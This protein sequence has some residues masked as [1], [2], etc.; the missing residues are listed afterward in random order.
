MR[1][2]RRLASRLGGGILGLA[3]LAALPYLGAAATSTEHSESSARIGSRCMPATFSSR[4][5][6][7]GSGI[8]NGPDLV[9]VDTVSRKLSPF[10]ISGRAR[11]APPGPLAKSWSD[12]YPSRIAVRDDGRL[13]VQ[14]EANGFV[15]LD[16]T[17]AY[18]RT[19]DASHLRDG[20][21][22]DKIYTWAPAG[23]DVVAFADIKTSSR[24]GQGEQWSSGVVRFSL[25]RDQ[26]GAGDRLLP[27]LSVHDAS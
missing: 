23:T 22:V 12:L 14:A 3:L 17:Y 15:L 7:T 16:R 1:F 13:V 5:L 27:D 18:Q 10:S 24:N 25:E 4:P 26:E 20:S 8:F 11:L 2:R 9:L 21:V 6:W 19:V